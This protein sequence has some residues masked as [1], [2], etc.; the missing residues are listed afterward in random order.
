MG[1]SGF[2]SSTAFPDNLCELKYFCSN[3]SWK[4][5]NHVSCKNKMS[6]FIN[7]FCV[8]QIL[9]STLL[10]LKVPFTRLLVN[11]LSILSLRPCLQL[12][13]L[14]VALVAVLRL[15]FKGTFI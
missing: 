2:S 15:K 3:G 10:I 6:T 4:L 5:N 7:N 13:R 14:T 9:V 8:N 11:E 1:G 12:K